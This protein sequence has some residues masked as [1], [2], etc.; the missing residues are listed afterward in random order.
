MFLAIALIPL[1][2]TSA[3]A[4]HNYRYSLENIRTEQM[5]TLALFKA[6][7]VQA[8]FARI[9]SFAKLLQ[10]LY[11]IK[12]NIPALIRLADN[13]AAPEYASIEI[14]IDN[15]LRTVV[16][17][18]GMFDL[19]LTDTRGRLIYHFKHERAST[20]PFRPVPDA[21]IKNIEKGGGAICISDMYLNILNDNRPALLV[22][23]PVLDMNEK[24]MGFIAIE[25]DMAPLYNLVMDKSGLGNTG[26]IVI[27]KKA[28]GHVIYL[29]PLRNDPQAALK[30]QVTL[31]APV[32]V[33]IQRA[34]AGREGVGMSVDYRGEKV[35]AAW[36]PV[37]GL[38][39]G[40]VIKIDAQEAFADA[41]NLRDLILFILGIVTILS[42]IMAFSIAHSISRPIIQ[43]S[44]AAQ[45]I[46]NG[47][48][49]FQAAGNS[50]DE[51]GQLAQSIEKM[52]INL[53]KLGS[54][55]D[56]ER[57]RLYGVMETLP[58]YVILLTED[59]RVPFAN[60]FFRERFG[61]SGGKRCYE[62][63]FNRP[64]PCDNCETYK[65]LKTGKPH[66]WEW[67]G[68]DNR[69]YDIH[70][71]P[72]RDTD[73]TCMILEMG[74]DITVQ[75]RAQESLRAAALYAR[76]LIEASLD[77]LV[78]ISAAGKITD[79]NEATIKVTGVPREELVG[80][81]FLDYFTEPEKARAGYKKV[82]TDGFVTDYP[83]T[84]RSKD[85]RL[86]DVLYNAS[87]YKD[88]HGNVLGVFA[89]ARDVTVLKQAEA[90][91]R[92]HRDNLEALVKERTAELQMILD[93]VPAMIF[94]KDKKNNFIRVNKAFENAM[95]LPIHA[96]EGK[97]LFDIYPKDTAE[98]YWKDDLEIINSGK[99][100][101]G[102]IEPMKSASGLK[103]VQTDKVPYFDKSGKIAG[104]IGF[105]IDITE[106]KRAEDALRQS[107]LL[108][109]R[110]QKLAHLGSWELDIATGQLIWSDEVYDI[111]GFKPQE[112][113]ATYKAFLETV[114][115]DDRAAVHSLYSRSLGD[116]TNGYE[117]EHRI[118]KKSTGD[119]RIVYEKCEHIRDSSGKVIRSAGMV[120]DVTEL[121]K[122]QAR[123]K[124]ALAIAT[125]ARTA[126]DS[127]QAMGEGVMLM[128]MNGCILSINPAF[129]QLSGY[130]KNKMLGRPL[131]D[132]LPIMLKEE[133]R[134]KALEIF[135]AALEGKEASLPP[136]TFISKQ[137]NPVPVMPALTFIRTTSGN[138]TAMVLTVRDISEIRAMQ[139]NLEENYDRMRILA[140]KLASTE[141]RERYRLSAQIH[142]TV[143]QTLALSNIKLGAL[144]K[145]LTA[146]GTKKSIEEV[147]ALRVTIKDA[148]S[149]SRS[150]MAELTPPLLYELGLGPALNDLAQKLQAKHNIP[151]RVN[152]DQNAKHLDR[153]IQ[154]IIF[155]AIRELIMNALKH[156]GQCNITVTLAR[157][158]NQ[159]R[160]C[161]EDNGYGF[162]VPE[163]GRFQFRAGGGFGL[164]FIRERLELIGG[165]ISINSRPGS[166]ASISLCVPW[167]EQSSLLNC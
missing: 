50:R 93:S 71:F 42:G 145:E 107:E 136:T 148:I 141:E 89:A 9:N 88:S 120:H 159:L 62:Y 140:E 126:M 152:D 97:S 111:F 39:W 84:I 82:F 33:P 7:E 25:M 122:L 135:R 76:S 65:V 11:V 74:I 139:K 153:S 117:I 16:E 160:A 157:D 133:E 6:Q 147:T 110:S 31:G 113:A 10:N 73:G 116:S 43:L 20:Q 137:G 67:T 118:I 151:I 5:R 77:P 55:R 59:Y 56:A 41:K 102:I 156:A 95:G 57:Q 91:L 90:E 15:I 51:I 161:V 23:A 52:T 19:M 79:V 24:A 108:L 124:E 130:N 27:G 1:L 155:Q 86:T 104:I 3:L 4:F 35:I 44:S 115:P 143:I 121:R 22:T 48:W 96:L 18:E 72:F 128:D 150:L 99:N 38:D 37:P 105:S 80:T 127:L 134:T 8:F 60:K 158:N 61:E 34:V 69:N 13:P 100:N 103:M 83:L 162:I 131:I 146:S 129:E 46:G 32:G 54:E 75:K 17:T 12:N 78:T 64:E 66:H 36:R 49:D 114:H 30:R 142:D 144:L 98:A 112:F 2:L 164:F 26:E 85:G 109:K 154:A 87:V 149:E 58:V 47:S 92:R 125:A 68:P 53:K 138:P 165:S 21:I 29:T 63:L 132:L 106:R 123:E 45:E 94:Y 163:E 119:V 70:D 166:G 28:D 14:L 167:H 40:L 101:L 81:D